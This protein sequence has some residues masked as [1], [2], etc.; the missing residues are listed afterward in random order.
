MGRTVTVSMRSFHDMD[1]KVAAIKGARDLSNCTLREAKDLVERVT[2][3]H[4]ET[5]MIGH[6]VLEPRFGEA[7]RLL[8]ESGLTVQVNQ[9]NSKVR[10]GIADQIRSLVTF[11]TMSA[12]YDIAKALIDVMETYCP[13]PAVEDDDE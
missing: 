10:R 5:I 2:P 1:N 13:E 6:D 11:S 7:I 4:S 12:Q 3:G 9:H 8:K